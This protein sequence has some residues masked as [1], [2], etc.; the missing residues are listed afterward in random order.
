[1]GLF[2]E[3]NRLMPGLRH[4]AESHKDIELDLI[5]N[6]ETMSIDLLIADGMSSIPNPTRYPLLYF[7][8]MEGREYVGKFKPRVDA[9]I[10]KYKEERRNGKKGTHIQSGTAQ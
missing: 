3:K 1:M 5:V 9:I 8:E 7:D 2:D 10:T 4:I 6:M